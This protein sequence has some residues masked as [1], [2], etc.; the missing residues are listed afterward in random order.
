MRADSPLL[1]V[2]DLVVKYRVTGG[3]GDFLTA[4]NG[5]SFDIHAG[6]IFGLVG[7][8]GSGKT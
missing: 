6:G 4:V 3:R 1:S 8:S 5:V 2:R 7:E